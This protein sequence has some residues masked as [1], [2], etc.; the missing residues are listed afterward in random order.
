MYGKQ[1][2]YVGAGHGVAGNVAVF[3]RA[4]ELLPRDRHEQ[5]FERIASL[6]DRYA[7]SDGT[8]T[9]W[10]SLAEPN[11][12]NRLQWCHGAPGIIMSLRRMPANASIDGMLLQGGAAIQSAGALK[13]GPTICHGTAGNGFALLYLAERTNGERWYEAA[14]RFAVHAIGQAAAW[15]RES[16]MRSASLMTGEIGVALFADAVLRNDARLLSIDAM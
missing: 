3:L 16:G 9:N 11:F 6:L 1:Q 8:A 14:R 13:K 12:G 5:L 2:R 7:V 15:E 10:W 4:P